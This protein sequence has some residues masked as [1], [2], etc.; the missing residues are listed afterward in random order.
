MVGRGACHCP[1]A[2]THTG[3]GAT[4]ENPAVQ[5]A[6]EAQGNAHFWVWRL[7]L[8]GKQVA[9]LWQGSASGLAGAGAAAGGGAPG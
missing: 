6:A 8:L 9:S 7:H 4:Q 2:G 1:V 5:S 3:I